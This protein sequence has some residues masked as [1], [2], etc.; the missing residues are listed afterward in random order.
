MAQQPEN[1]WQSCSIPTET[2]FSCFCY[3]CFD[4]SSMM[5]QATLLFTLL[6]W[7]I[8]DYHPR[9]TS[10]VALIYFSG[11]DWCT[12]CILFENKVLSDT[13]FT[14]FLDRRAI[15]LE[16]IDFPQR[17]RLTREQISYN[18]L[19]AD[20]YEFDGTFPTLL[21]GRTDTLHFVKLRYNNQ[22]ASRL[23]EEITTKLNQLQ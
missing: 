20:R 4:R 11:S 13:T 8:S 7:L 15:A 18:E 2:G 19:V 12:E 14:N 1:E 10:D 3:F 17:K 22:P 9:E 16:K 21:L 23:I 5:H 6:T